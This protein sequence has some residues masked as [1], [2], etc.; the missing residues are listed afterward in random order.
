MILGWKLRTMASWYMDKEK[1]YA[2]IE[3]KERT[4]NAKFET[5]AQSVN[6]LSCGALPAKKAT[7][8]EDAKAVFHRDVGSDEAVIA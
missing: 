7:V 5:I 8:G 1:C 2:D 4:W 6:V 3:Q